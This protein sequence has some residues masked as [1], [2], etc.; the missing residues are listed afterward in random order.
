MTSAVPPGRPYR[1]PPTLIIALC[2]TDS[3]NSYK[4]RPGNATCNYCYPIERL[5]M[6]RTKTET[7][8]QL[9]AAYAD[10]A[11]RGAAITVRSLR[12]TAG[13]SMAAAGEWLRVNRPA[14]TT[15]PLPLEQV[16]GTLEAFWAMTFA[17]ARDEVA[18]DAAAREAA[19]ITAEADVLE[20]LAAAQEAAAAMTAQIEEARTTAER[21]GEQ[22]RVEIEALRMQL[23]K[24]QAEAERERET[25]RSAEGRASRAE[26]TAEILQRLVDVH[27]TTV[28]TG[29]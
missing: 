1:R 12:E 14:Q 9:A 16:S 8:P 21:A 20:Q 17:A 15:P 28:P 13:V 22:A 19:L 10:L 11:K 29:K 26:A 4:K 25:A 27:M 18:T 2:S 3:Y 7:G 5:T 6:P 23:E 24:S